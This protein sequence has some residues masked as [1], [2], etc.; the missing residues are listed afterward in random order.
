MISF[1]QNFMNSGMQDTLPTGITVKEILQHA[2]GRADVA[3]FFFFLSKLMQR[4]LVFPYFLQGP[5]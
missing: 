5:M 1:V 4:K 2:A 3:V